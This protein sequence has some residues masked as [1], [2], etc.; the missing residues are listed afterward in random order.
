MLILTSFVALDKGVY[1]LAAKIMAYS[2][3]HRGPRPNFLCPIMYTVLTEG[4]DHTEP[5]IGDLPD[6]ELQGKIQA[7]S[8]PRLIN[9][10][11][12]MLAYK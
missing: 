9:A 5:Q 4:I 3:V 11:D 10:L 1:R 2:I 12:V 8:S 6:Y 7:V